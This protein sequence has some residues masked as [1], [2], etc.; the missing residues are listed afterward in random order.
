MKQKKVMVFGV[1]DSIH[2]GH[3]AFLKE[4]RAE[5]DYLIAVVTQDHVVQ[6]LKGEFPRINLAERFKRLAQEENV[7]EV[8]VGDGELRIWNVVEKQRPDVIAVGYDQALLKEDLESYFKHKEWRP[9]IK[10]MRAHEPNVY[11]N[12]L[13]KNEGVV[14]RE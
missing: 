5:G 4:A 1:F 10:V 3:R 7:N 14:N 12:S 9:E 13:L 8:V 11:H 2:E 6:R